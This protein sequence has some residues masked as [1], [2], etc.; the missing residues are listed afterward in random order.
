MCRPQHQASR[1]KPRGEW[2]REGA[3]KSRKLSSRIIRSVPTLTHACAVG[4]ERPSA[5]RGRGS[6]A[7]RS[8]QR[9]EHTPHAS[10]SQSCVPDGETRG[11]GEGHC[12]RPTATKVTFRSTAGT[13]TVST[14]AVFVSD[15]EIFQTG[16]CDCRERHF[17]WKSRE[18]FLLGCMAPLCAMDPASGPQKCSTCSM[19]TGC[20]SNSPFRMARSLSCKGDIPPVHC[21]NTH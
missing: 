19:A 18:P 5:G 8:H 16:G 11:G 10:C 15:R 12:P 17:S 6:A 7:S 14:V 21:N 1:N 2:T 20:W 9:P 4:M 3:F 13:I